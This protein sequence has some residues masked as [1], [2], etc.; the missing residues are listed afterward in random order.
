M[1]NR[2]QR[3]TV[4]ELFFHSTLVEAGYYDDT[5]M[6][7]VDIAEPVF[8]CIGHDKDGDAVAMHVDVFKPEYLELSVDEVHKS[9]FTNPYTFWVSKEDIKEKFV[10]EV[11]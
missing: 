8:I 2:G 4:T 6:N 10:E 11:K 1:L 5:V 7:P 9:A 3:F